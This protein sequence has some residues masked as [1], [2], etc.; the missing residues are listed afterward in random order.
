MVRPQRVAHVVI[1]VT[2]I[3]R[4]LRFYC[5]GLGMARTGALGDQMVFLYF[6]E[7][8][9]APHPYYHDIALYRV[10]RSA[11][12][13]FRKMSGAN[14]VAVLMNSPDDVDAAAEQLRQGEFTILKGPA[15]HKEDGYRYLYV[16]DPD[17]NVIELI[18]PTEAT[19]AGARTQGQTLL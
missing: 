19:Y 12:E 1:N 14:H 15:T 7:E 10:D 5:Q 16:E 3:D 11:P 6:G 4:S 9:Q 8:G 18:A 17:R 13:D 2:D